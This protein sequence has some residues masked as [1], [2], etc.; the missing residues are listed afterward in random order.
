[1]KDELF[2]TMDPD[3][4]GLTVLAGTEISKIIGSPF[5]YNVPTRGALLRDVGNGAPVKTCSDVNETT[6]I[7]KLET[8]S[9]NKVYSEKG[10]VIVQGTNESELIRS[11]DRLSLTVLG[12]MS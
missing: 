12:V 9:E 3:A 10:C 11:A 4:T 2:I 1:L 5:L 8:G 6:S 7:V